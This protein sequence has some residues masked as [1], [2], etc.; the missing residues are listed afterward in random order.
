MSFKAYSLFHHT[1]NLKLNLS[2][3]IPNCE[4]HGELFKIKCLS[5][6]D[7]IKYSFEAYPQLLC[8]RWVKMLPVI[9]SWKKKYQGAIQGVRLIIVIEP[10][11][12]TGENNNLPLI[13]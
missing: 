12:V 4:Q 5:E 1:S 8:G 6:I 7:S 13:I 3:S 2:K 11:K 10:V 9:N